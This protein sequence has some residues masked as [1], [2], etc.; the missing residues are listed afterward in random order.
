[1]ESVCIDVLHTCDQGF[2]SHVA[3]NIFYEC[4]QK[5]AFCAGTIA[6]NLAAL[7]ILLDNWYKQHKPTSRVKGQLT[8]ERVKTSW[9]MA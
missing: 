5:H 6:A 3:G 4:I 7:N 2:A 1:M 9:G 8:A